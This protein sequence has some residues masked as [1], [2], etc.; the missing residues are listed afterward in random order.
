V[1]FHNERTGT[2]MQSFPT[3]GRTARQSFAKRKALPVLIES[4]G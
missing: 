1:S 2:G 4:R 3:G